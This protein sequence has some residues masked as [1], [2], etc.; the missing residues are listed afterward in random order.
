M[1]VEGGLVEKSTET[2]VAGSILTVT[3]L[4]YYTGGG[5]IT[6]DENGTWSEP[7]L[8]SCTPSEAHIINSQHAC[9]RVTV[10]V[11]SLCVCVCLSDRSHLASGAYVRP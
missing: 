10:V 2:L 7:E 5:N 3:C 4:K 9:T 11:L 8:P 1:S 6:C